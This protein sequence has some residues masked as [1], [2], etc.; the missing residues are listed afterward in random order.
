MKN[1]NSLLNECLREC[2][3]V[4]IQYGNIVEASINKR[5]ARRWGQCVKKANGFHIS[6]N[7]V[8]LE[9]DVSDEA[10]KNTIVHEI[11]HTVVGCQNHGKKWKALAKLMNDTYGYSIKRCD[12][13][14][15]KGVD[16]SKLKPD[17]YE[18]KC[19]KC[20]K[21][22]S[23]YKMSQIIKYPSRYI[24]RGCGGSFIRSK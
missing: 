21:V 23:R 2:D 16:G 13:K 4:G 3:A 12:S 17:R 5:F 18:I 1:L 10:A 20:G 22:Y 8:L 7:A 24:H 9:D 11:L 15:E 19:E 6:I 14:E